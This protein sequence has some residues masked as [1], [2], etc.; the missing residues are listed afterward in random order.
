MVSV[1]GAGEPWWGPDS[2][3]L[4]Y[5]TGDK[6]MEATLA[7]APTLSVVAR[8]VVFG[9]GYASDIYHPDYDV[10][11]DGASFVMVRPVES[12]RRVVIVVNWVRELRRRMVGTR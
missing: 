1:G 10:A 7:T 6:V 3:R 8:R 9:G 2:R 11:P 5:R 12:S 4:Y